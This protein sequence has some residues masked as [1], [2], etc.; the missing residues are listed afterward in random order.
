[1]QLQN[2]LR[3]L[4]QK[5]DAALT[6]GNGQKD[7]LSLGVIHLLHCFKPPATKMQIPLN[8]SFPASTWN[9]DNWMQARHA[10]TLN[11]CNAQCREV[12][13]AKKLQKVPQKLRT[14][15]LLS[16]LDVASEQ[17]GCSLA[18]FQFLL[19]QLREI[20]LAVSFSSMCQVQF[21]LY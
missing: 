8:V 20:N 17:A 9:R 12:T 11:L 7:R 6:D 15:R 4:N 14:K 10:V 5:V 16:P 19:H 21:A 3:D 1:M 18:S 13:R 2:S